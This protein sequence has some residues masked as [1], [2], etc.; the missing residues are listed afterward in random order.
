MTELKGHVVV[1]RT[2]PMGRFNS[3]RVEVMEEYDLS[4]TTFEEKFD[5]LTQRL[6]DKM[7]QTGAINQ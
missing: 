6:K 2:V 4:R 5:E 7:I 1:G 3:F